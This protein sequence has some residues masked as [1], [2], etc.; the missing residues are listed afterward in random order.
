MRTNTIVHGAAP[1]LASCVATP[2]HDGH[3]AAR[4]LNPHG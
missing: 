1:G 2:E 3:G 4:D